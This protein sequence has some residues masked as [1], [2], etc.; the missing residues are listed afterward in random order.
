MDKDEVKLLKTMII[1]YVLF[2]INEFLQWLAFVGIWA[3]IIS[4]DLIGWI[5]RVI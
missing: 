4:E 3:D 5:N 2:L 1:L